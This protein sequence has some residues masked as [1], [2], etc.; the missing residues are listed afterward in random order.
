MFQSI[1]KGE[2]FLLVAGSSF[3]LLVLTLVGFGRLFRNRM[4]DHG[5]E[6][7]AL[8][9]SLDLS[10]GIL[11]YLVLALIAP[12]VS[13]HRPLA[14]LF[15]VL[16][17][18]KGF[19][20]LRFKRGTDRPGREWAAIIS[21]SI[22][23]ILVIFRS[24]LEG[25]DSR[26]IWFLHSK[27]IVFSGTT[28]SAAGWSLPEF[29]F[30]HPDYP[31]LNSILSSALFFSPW[32]S[33]FV[34]WSDGLAKGSLVIFFL[35]QMAGW[36]ALPRRTSIGSLAIFCI[37]FMIPGQ[38]AWNGYMDLWTA[39]FGLLGL[40]HA[41]CALAGPRFSSHGVQSLVF[42]A[43]ALHCKL[44]GAVAAACIICA[45]F[46]ILPVRQVAG[47]GIRSLVNRGGWVCLLSVIVWYEIRSRLGVENDLGGVN[48]SFLSRVLARAT[49]GQSVVEIF[50]SLFLSAS[51][52]GVLF[53]FSFFA[54]MLGWR[55]KASREDARMSGVLLLTG[56][57][58][59]VFLVVVYLGTPNDLLWHLGTSANRVTLFAT[60]C[61][62]V[63]VLSMSGV[64][65]LSF[66]DEG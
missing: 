20:L 23:L 10:L 12:E 54:V 19:G 13:V 24:P 52:A 38:K 42:L 57:G 39:N 30:S 6:A 56:M 46:L 40:L 48:W 53:L 21:L 45:S 26:S 14:S 25:W 33:A 28:G 17:W 5:D 44:E 16:G 66:R 35:A 31:R 37:L 58:Y 65:T 36:V 1:V 64:W 29:S 11:A 51:H 22:V 47:I 3:V 32:G 60:Q 49:D 2:W 4:S 41:L 18:A 59:M 63:S 8:R 50:R 43:L 34:S 62:T 55:R 7:W 61:W 9:Q 15:A 27:L